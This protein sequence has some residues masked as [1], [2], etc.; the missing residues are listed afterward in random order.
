MVGENGRV[1]EEGKLGSGTLSYD[2][3]EDMVAHK[4]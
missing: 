3:K 1:F 4:I 2:V